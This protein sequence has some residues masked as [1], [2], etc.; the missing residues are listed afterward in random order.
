[1]SAVLEKVEI[2]GV[3]VPL[4]FEQDRHLPIASMQ[5]VFR[6][7]GALADGTLPGLAKFSAR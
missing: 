5:V 7:S 6:Y 1:M 2:G 4:I 3:A